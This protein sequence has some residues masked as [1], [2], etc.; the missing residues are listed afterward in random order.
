MRQRFLSIC[1]VLVAA[2]WPVAGTQSGS[3]AP[4]DQSKPQLTY[5]VE[6]NYVE[7]DAVVTDG[8]GGFV[9]D[10]TRD[11]FELQEDGKPMSIDTFLLVDI[12]LEHADAPLYR[13]TPVEPDVVTNER[14]FDGRV[15]PIVLDGYHVAPLRTVQAKRVATDFITNYMA[16]NDMAAVVQIGHTNHSQDFTS[17]KR[18]LLD[19]VDKF[20]GEKL[21]SAAINKFDDVNRAVASDQPVQDQDRAERVGQARA[22]VDSLRQLSGYMA[23]MRGRRKAVMFVS[24]GLS[25]DLDNLVSSGSAAQAD[26]VL[27]M[28]STSGAEAS[29]ASDIV[30]D[31]QKMLEAATRSN[32]SFYSVDPRGLADPSE[33]LITVGGTID[34][35][36][37][38]PPGQAAPAPVSVEPPVAA[39][40]TELRR[41]Q[42]MLRTLADQTGGLATVGT[43][44]FND[45]FGRIVQD[46]T[47]YYV[48]AYHTEPKRDGK[49]HKITVRVTRPGVQVRARKGYYSVKVDPKAPPPP[50]PD[51]LRDLLTSPMAISGLRLRATADAL[52]GQG[53]AGLVQL[54]V[55]LDGAGLSFENQ[56]DVF[57]NTVDVSYLAVDENGQTKGSGKKSLALSLKPQNRDAVVQHGLRYATELS[58]PPGRYQ[59]RVAAHETVGDSAGSVFWDSRG[60]RL[61]ETRS[62]DERPDSDLVPVRGGA[63]DQRRDHPQ[64]RAARPADRLADV[65]ARGD[66]GGLRRHL[67]ERRGGG[68]A[69]RGHHDDRALRRRHAGL[70]ERRSARQRQPQRRPRDVPVPGPHPAAGPGAR[71]LRPHRGGAVPAGRRPGQ[72]RDRVRDQVGAGGS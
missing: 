39:L 62:D 72:E 50:P 58:L 14:D 42:G 61:C 54:T 37:P 38:G 22:T 28:A 10:L 60:A 43:N 5:S 66:A 11:D 55:E 51:V 27:G 57:T 33:E 70:Q 59:L 16:A 53:A 7:V 1:V 71:P 12:P 49:F 24:E 29:E 63:D 46:N 35:T 67:R 48:L 30:D 36:P 13:A 23:G 25:V 52:K 41:S 68:A 15:Y 3:A 21:P 19:A 47:T 44:N 8:K 69:R 4:Q 64:G 40:T 26:D 32:I 18:L 6:A 31:M 34:A 20:I 9:R 45:G 2:A 56:N 65:H 17:N